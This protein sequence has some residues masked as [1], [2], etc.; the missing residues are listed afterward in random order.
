MAG[1][2]AIE[3]MFVAALM[4]ILAAIAVPQAIGSIAR[5]RGLIAAKYLG[6]KCA[7][8]RSLA[9]SRGAAIGLRF[10][11]DSRGFTF[12]IY[13]DGNHNGVR[14]IDIQRRVDRLIEPSI[15]LSDLFAGADI[16]IAPGVPESD[17]LQIGSANILTFTPAGTATS[18]TIY[19]R[20][21][22]GTQWAVRILGAT[23]R[24]RVLKYVLTTRE[25][26]DAF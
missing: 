3:L 19:V 4:S 14:T 22:D 2:T 5:A 1:Y 9:V 18:G 16:G 15:R 20:G 24:T 26:T 25:W 11:S 8:A 12:A 21:Q 10:V 7:L 6:G 17:P 23:G 13:Q